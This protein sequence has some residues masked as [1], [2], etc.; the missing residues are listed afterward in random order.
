MTLFC[1]KKDSY[2]KS[3]DTVK[4]CLVSYQVL[5]RSDFSLSLSLSFFKLRSLCVVLTV[6]ELCVWRGWPGTYRDPP[7]SLC[8]W[9]AS[10]KA[11]CHR[12]W[13]GLEILYIVCGGGGGWGG[14][15]A[16]G[17]DVE[18]RGQP[19]RVGSFL[20]ST[21]WVPGIKF[22]LTGLLTGAFPH[23]AISLAPSFFFYVTNS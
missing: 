17:M 2:L 13:Q 9:N 21:V 14:L 20:P 1:V 23:W 16:H 4:G 6:L 18:V 22:W 12:I 15:L 10:I 5:S 19:A 11:I 8:L 3:K 7:A